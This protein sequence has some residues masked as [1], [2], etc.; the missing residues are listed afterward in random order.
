MDC[1]TS[2]CAIPLHLDRLHIRFQPVQFVRELPFGIVKQMLSEK[3]QDGFL[4]AF[5]R[6]GRLEP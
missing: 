3:R 1:D 2:Q 4:V 6:F 5:K